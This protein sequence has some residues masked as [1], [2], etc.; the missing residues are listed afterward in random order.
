MIC[1]VLAVIHYTCSK[2]FGSLGRVLRLK[3]CDLS[4]GKILCELLKFSLPP[5]LR[6]LIPK[7]F[8]V[9]KITKNKATNK[10]G[11][12]QNK[13]TNQRTKTKQNKTKQIVCKPFKY[14]HLRNEQMIKQNVSYQV[15]RRHLH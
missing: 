13:Q 14:I 11:R 15:P 1:C 6:M 8:K 5:T 2:Y 12:K 4:T 9:Y 3:A 10:R 7:V